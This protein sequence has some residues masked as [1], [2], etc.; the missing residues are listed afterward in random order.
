[1]KIKTDGKWYTSKAP[2]ELNKLSKKE[3]PEVPMGLQGD[4]ILIKLPDNIIKDFFPRLRKYQMLHEFR[5]LGLK[6]W[7]LYKPVD[8]FSGLVVTYNHESGKYKIGIY[9]HDTTIEIESLVTK[10]VLGERAKKAWK[11]RRG[12]L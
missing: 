3:R 12:L 11:T 2:F 9:E 1:M 7:D 5:N 6:G 4:E 10:E 8:F